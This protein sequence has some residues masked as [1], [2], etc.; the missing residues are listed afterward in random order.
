MITVELIQGT[1]EWHAHRAHHHN[2]SDAP[3]MLGCSPY[4]TRAQLVRECATGLTAEVDPAT[5]KRFDDGHRYEA[6]ARPLAEEIVGEDL[7]PVVGVQGK[8]SASFD[9]LTLLEDTA[10]EH[11]SLNDEL[12]R[13]MVDGCTGADLPEHYRIQM[14]QQMLVS[15]AHRVLFM[16]SK[17]DGAGLVEARDTYYLPD[18]ALRD[19]II[20]GWELF[21]ADVAAYESPAVAEVVTKPARIAG[22]ALPSIFVQVHGQ[23]TVTENFQAF[24]ARALEFLDRELIRSPQTDDDFGALEGQIKEIKRAEAALEAAG[25]QILAQVETIDTVMRRKDQL[26]KLLRDNRLLAEKLL[27]SEKE[28][29]RTEIV[30]AGRKAVIGHYEKINATM[31]VHALAVPLREITSD[32]GGAI[33]GKR[34]LSSMQDAVDGMAAQHKVVA[35]QIADRIRANVAILAEHPDHAGLFA[36]RVALCATKAPEDLRNLVAA[37]IA[38]HQQREA[39]RLEQE[40][41]R[42]RQEEVA[43][44][45]REQAQREAEQR[46]AEADEQKRAELQRQQNEIVEAAEAVTKEAAPAAVASPA[47]LAQQ[48]P[49]AAARPGARI[50]L[51]DIN[52]AIA[53][54]SISGDGL[55]LLGFQPGATDRAAKLYDADQFRAMCIAMRG[56]LADAVRKVEETYPLA[57]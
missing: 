41:E 46:Q 11:K 19:R 7:Y 23:V 17:W 6:L 38:E 31:G 32:L 57:A 36:D 13:V 51:S 4:K 5:Q 25:S 33:K 34:S 8:Y 44:M 52:A 26:S 30:E 22:E 49:A 24:E 18:F 50:K 56:S 10:F 43:R 20:A 1:P 12:R 15:G 39:A 29:R 9:G 3:A 48:A 37:R 28:R 53:P 45:E 42:I 47:P 14:E 21:E 27:T 35:S 40:R 16:A 54:L 55:A 2:A